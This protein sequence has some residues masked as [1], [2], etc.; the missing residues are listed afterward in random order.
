ML[1]VKR[2][3]IVSHLNVAFYETY[4]FIFSSAIKPSFAR[5]PL[6]STTSASQGGNLTIQCQ[7]EAA[8]QPDITWLHN[9]Q[10]I[11]YG[12][13]RRQILLDGTLHI[14]QISQSDQGMYTCKATNINGED[15]SS[16]HV[17][18]MGT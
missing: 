15:Q 10:A 14:I 12:D 13:A 16:T 7:P 2:R 8:P 5:Y 17:L 1:S 6:P 4:S 3:C 11:G 18:V 9:G